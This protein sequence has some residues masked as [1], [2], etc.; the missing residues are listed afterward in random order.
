MSLLININFE[1]WKNWKIG[2]LVSFPLCDS[3]DIESA[4]FSSFE[5]SHPSDKVEVGTEYSSNVVRNQVLISYILS[6]AK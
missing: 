5:V 3:T 6:V 1:D 2:K 4:I